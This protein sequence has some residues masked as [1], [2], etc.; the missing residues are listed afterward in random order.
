MEVLSR[1]SGVGS[2]KLGARSWKQGAVCHPER[3]E[4]SSQRKT[5]VPARPFISSQKSVTLLFASLKFPP[6]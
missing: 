1:E 5:G 2:Q 6:S 4:G 3:S